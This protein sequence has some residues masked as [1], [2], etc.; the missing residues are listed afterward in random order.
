MTTEQNQ[1]NSLKINLVPTFLFT[2]FYR[3][4]FR[5]AVLL[6]LLERER[7]FIIYSSLVQFLIFLGFL[8][9]DPLSLVELSLNAVKKKKG[10]LAKAALRKGSKVLP[11][12][13]IHSMRM[14]MD[15]SSFVMSSIESW[16]TLEAFSFSLAPPL[17]PFSFFSF[18][19]NT[20]SFGPW[21]APVFDDNRWIIQRKWVSIHSRH[22]LSSFPAFSPILAAR[23]EVNWVCRNVQPVEGYRCVKVFQEC[24]SSLWRYAKRLAVLSF[25]LAAVAAAIAAAATAVVV[26]VAIAVV[27]VGAVLSPSSRQPW[28][29]S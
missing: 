1:L 3:F 4:F 9:L 28:W 11:H 24:F 5:W 18:R 8:F 16:T 17:P 20:S 14:Q 12:C 6:F 25:F 22:R 19:P 29:L 7:P 13:S 15:A 21:R 10:R 27:M 23:Q 2:V 26:V